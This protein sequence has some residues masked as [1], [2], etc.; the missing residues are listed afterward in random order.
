[1]KTIKRGFF[2]L[3]CLIVIYSITSCAYTSMSQVVYLN[4]GDAIKVTLETTNGYKFNLYED[5]RLEIR[6]GS[7]VVAEGGFLTDVNYDTFLEEVEI[8]EENP[9]DLPNFY[10]FQFINDDSGLVY[11]FVQQIENSITSLHMLMNNLSFEDA[12]ELIQ[13]LQLTKVD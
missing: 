9:K 7:Q 5:G 10:F 12:Q 4:N 3:I 11:V 8:L 13:R 1:M 2:V 6:K